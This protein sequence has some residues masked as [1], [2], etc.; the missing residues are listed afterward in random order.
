LREY[1]IRASGVA[2]I[3][4]DLEND[5]W[6]SAPHGIESIGVDTRVVDRDSRQGMALA[7]QRAK[8]SFEV[9]VATMVDD[10]DT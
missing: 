6:M 10:A 3:G 7:I 2:A 8:A 4:A 1:P 5:F 9:V